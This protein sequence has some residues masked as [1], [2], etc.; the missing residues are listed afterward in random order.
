M[1]VTIDCLLFFFFNFDHLL[2]MGGFSEIPSLTSA[3]PSSI[4]SISPILYRL[5]LPT[6]VAQF[7][8]TDL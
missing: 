2:K 5:G 7:L 6:G 8:N 3:C 4:R 1:E